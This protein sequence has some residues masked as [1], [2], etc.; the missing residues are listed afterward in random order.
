LDKVLEMRNGLAA[1]P[2]SSNLRLPFT[3]EI[4]DAC[5][6]APTFSPLVVYAIKVN[7]T[8]LSYQPD[9]LQK[10]AD[11]NTELMPDGSAAGHG[12]MMLTS[13]WPTE[14][15]LPYRNALYAIQHFLLPAEEFWARKGFEG[16]TLL[17]AIAAEFNSGRGGALAGHQQGDIGKLTTFE[18]GISYPDRAFIHYR[19]LLAGKMP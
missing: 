8:A 11:P 17:L 18:G 14:W 19:N 6:I 2:I 1:A 13:S 7:E 10:G 12:I 15:R 5:N 9:E 4:E 3:V 16:E